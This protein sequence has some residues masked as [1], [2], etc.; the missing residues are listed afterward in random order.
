MREGYGI[1]IDLGKE[2]ANIF[3][4]GNTL[5]TI[6]RIYWDMGYGDHNANKLYF[7][8]IN[9]YMYEN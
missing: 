1:L 4:E 6:S 9:D 7:Y 3:T 8:Q 5:T 2:D